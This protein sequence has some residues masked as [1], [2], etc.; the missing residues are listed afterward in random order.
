MAELSRIP[1]RIR[2]EG[3][4]ETSG[5]L[6]RF[7]APRTVNA[8]LRALPLEGRVA[9]SPGEIY[10]P[11]QVKVGLEKPRSLVEAGTIAYWPQGSALC[12]FYAQTKPYSPVN[13]VGRITG[14][15]E[16]LQQAKRG[17]V[18]KVEKT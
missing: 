8:L 11:I 13:L 4:G 16:I 5:E 2:L 6:V 12:L 18:V 17:T 14:S 15:L 1:L 10:F 7:W 3:L 9:L